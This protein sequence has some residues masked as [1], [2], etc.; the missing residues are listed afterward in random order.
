[1]SVVVGK[2]WREG[3][4]I[5]GLTPQQAGMGSRADTAEWQEN[6]L[7]IVYYTTPLGK[8]RMT[9]RDSWKQRPRVMRY[10]TWADG[11]RAAVIGRVNIPP[12]EKVASLSWRA[13]FEP[14]QWWPKKKRVAAIG[15]QHRIR[16]D[17]DNLL[18]AGMD[19]LFKK[20]A[21]IASVKIV[22]L[23]DWVARTEIEIEVV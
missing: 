4:Q 6:V 17:I 18:K 15:Q 13:Y 1:M 16:P 14:P 5:L 2:T 22:K 11:L 8:P 19:A 7:H 20:D 9:Q 23:W 3:L 12:A 21:G 10:R